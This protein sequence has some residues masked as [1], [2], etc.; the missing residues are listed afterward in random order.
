MQIAL[1]YSLYHDM[2]Q[3]CKQGFSDYFSDKWNY[4]DVVYIILG[5]VN[6]QL[7]YSTKTW[8]LESK[9]CFIAVVLLCL[10]KTFFYMRIIMSYSY[11]VTMIVNVIAD[12]RVFLLFF[13]ILIL[14]FSAIFDVIAKSNAPE[15]DK[16]GPFLGNFLLTLRLSLGN[17]D[18]GV[19]TDDKYELNT[20]QHWLF[21]I[22]WVIMVLFSSLIFLNFIIAE[23]SNSYSNVK[24]NIDALIYKERAGLIDEVENITTNSTISKHKEMW[25]KFVVVR[26]LE[27]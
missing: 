21:W 10:V 3:L 19:L 2:F 1:F 24:V 12:L 4:L 17:F 18:F 22:V 26:E 20:L 7:Q 11:I 8:A 13:T 9:L 5:Y 16:V 15:Y 27:D 14:M 23:V 6:I 25:P